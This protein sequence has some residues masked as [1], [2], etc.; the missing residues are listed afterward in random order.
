MS[1]L[2]LW[3]CCVAYLWAVAASAVPV[4]VDPATDG[5]PISIVSQALL[6]ELTLASQWVAA[7]YCKD[8]FSR[9][10]HQVSCQP[11]NCPLVESAQTN[12]LAVVN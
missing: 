12:V 7:S 2:C 11:G 6:D 8:N 1:L 3:V 4:V 5:F 9:T 10:Q